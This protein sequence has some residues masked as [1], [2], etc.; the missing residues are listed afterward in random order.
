MQEVEGGNY[1]QKG[2][3]NMRKEG[4]NDRTCRKEGRICRREKRIC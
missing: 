4:R 1:I 3:V 2:E